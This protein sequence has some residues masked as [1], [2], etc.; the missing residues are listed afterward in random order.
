MMRLHTI[1]LLLTLFF[2]SG[3]QAQQRVARSEADK[4]LDLSRVFTNILETR[5]GLD[6]LK[7]AAFDNPCALTQ[8]SFTVD[9]AW[10]FVAGM[11][12]YEDREKAQL[13][14]NDMGEAVQINSALVYFS[15]A[16]AVNNGSLRVKIYSFDPGTGTPGTLLGQSED[17]TVEDL[18]VSEDEFVA[19]SFPFAEPISVD[20][21][22]FFLSVDVSDLYATSDTVGIYHTDFGCGSGLEAY[23]LWS[24]DSWVSI[25]DAWLG[26]QDFNI[27]F[28]IFAI[29]GDETSAVK[30]P[31][32]Q[33]GHLRLRPA[34]PTP[35]RNSVQL[36]YDMEQPGSVQIDIFSPDGR[37]IEHRQL[38]QRPV[39]SYTETVDLSNFVRGTYFYSILTDEASVVSRFIVE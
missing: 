23:E 17:L 31:A 20:P 35:A 6:T 5:M 26:P 11:N 14:V 30:D 39:G 7:P 37:R 12:E 15:H 25:F 36:N 32:Y 24:D 9:N 16:S 3:L 8:R 33:K 27:N 2:T 29:T 19:T 13:I 34:T 21:G 1:L 28:S 22:S 18:Q 38:G 10:G 4:T